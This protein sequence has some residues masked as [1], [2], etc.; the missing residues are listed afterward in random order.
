[1]TDWLPLTANDSFLVVASDGVFE[2]MSSQ[3]VCDTLWKVHSCSDPRSEFSS[4]CSYPLADLI[5]NTALEK[6]SMDN[7]AT[8]VVPLESDVFSD[9]SFG[10]S[11]TEKRD[12][13][14]PLLGL[15]ESSRSSGIICGFRW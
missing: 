5:V 13:D 10:G 3:D 9:Y 8:V 2:K 15:Q 4:S 11:C 12:V 14:R 1:M 7:V 6:G